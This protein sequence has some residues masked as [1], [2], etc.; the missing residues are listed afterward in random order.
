MVNDQVFIDHF[1]HIM[2][3]C[4]HIQA[5]TKILLMVGGAQWCPRHYFYRSKIGLVDN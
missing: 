1:Y 2:L 4:V 3:L 5:L